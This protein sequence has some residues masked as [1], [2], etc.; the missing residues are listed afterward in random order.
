MQI[1]RKKKAA[2]ARRPHPFDVQFGV[3]TDGLIKGSDLAVGHA[4]DEH[5][6]A[7]YGVQ[8]SLFHELMDRWEQTPPAYPLEEYTFIDFGAGKGRAIM[9]AAEFPFREVIG[10]ELNPGLAAIAESNLQVW[11]AAGQAQSPMRILCQDATEF[12]FP[13]NPCVAYM[14]NP[15]ARPVLRSLIKSMEQSF[16]GRP[17]QLDILYVNDECE[18]SLRLH[19]GF[20]QLWKGRIDMSVEDEVAELITMD[21]QEDGEYAS[22]GW[23]SCSAYRWTGRGMGHENG[24]EKVPA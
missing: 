8:P 5:S 9:L 18:T 4:N 11:Q 20:T 23:E 21:A 16:T 2:R 12:V 10:I 14:F 17:G 24:R 13:S 1:V 19:R 7:Y 3:D 6:T 22:S 15:F